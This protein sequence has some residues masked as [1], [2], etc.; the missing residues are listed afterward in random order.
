MNAVFTVTY[1]WKFRAVIYTF[2]NQ[3]QLGGE[4]LAAIK[5]C[6]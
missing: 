1:S 5:D 3:Q 2:L 6:H 4:K